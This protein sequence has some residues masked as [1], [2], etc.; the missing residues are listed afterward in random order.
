MNVCQEGD[1]GRGVP[2]ARRNGAV[3]HPR[4]HSG[5][6]RR[7]AGGGLGERR[8]ERRCAGAVDALGVAGGEMGEDSLDEFGRFDARD[9]AQRTAEHATVFDVD[10]EKDVELI[11]RMA[12]LELLGQNMLDELGGGFR[13]ASR[14]TAWTEAAALATERHQLLVPA[15]I[16]LHTEESVF[17]APAFQ[18]RLEL[19][20]DEVGERDPFGIKACSRNRG[21]CSSTR[22]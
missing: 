15:G 9:D 10:E 1:G 20:D 13:H 14:A 4:A 16:A 7:G 5:Q 22:A 11:T 18:V 17:E 8:L 12:R 19:F 2:E 6:G 3:V 21:K